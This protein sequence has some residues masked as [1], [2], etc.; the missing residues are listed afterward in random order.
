MAW[1]WSALLAL[2]LAT[3]AALMRSRGRLSRRPTT[4][5]RVDVSVIIPARNEERS[6][7]LLLTSV[8]ELRPPPIEVIVVDDESVDDTARLARV[9][10]AHVVTSGPPPPGWTGK[11]WACH[12]GAQVSSASML[13]FLDADTIVASDALDVLLAAHA[14]QGGLLSVQPFHRTVRAHEQLSAYFNI[15]PVMASGALA[16]RAPGRPMAFGPCLLTSRRDYERSGGHAAVRAEVLD[17]ARLAGAYAAA[18][19]PVVC[20]LGG[21]VV[22]MRMY[23]GGLRQLV[24]GWTK[25]IASGAGQ[26]TRWAAAAAAFWMCGHWLVVGAVV[27]WSVDGLTPLAGVPDLPVP[28]V[29][30]GWLAVALQLRGMLHRVGSFRWWTWVMFPLPLLAFGLIFAWSVWLTVWRREVRWRGRALPTTGSRAS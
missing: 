12:R 25:N 10:S 6:L 17:D 14:R 13:L 7:P 20:R 4:Q 5:Q 8:R 9:A 24:E 16:V 2:A 19:M 23:P 29:L 15:V 3:G 11:A 27:S 28:V 18:G 26:A 30:V 21:D 1:T 22:S